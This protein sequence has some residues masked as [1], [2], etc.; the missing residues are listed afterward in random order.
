MGREVVHRPQGRATSIAILAALVFISACT[1]ASPSRPSSGAAPS[2]ASTEPARSVT[3]V[4]AARG[5][6]PSLSARPMRDFGLGGR[7]TVSLFS[8]G[9]AIKDASGT[10]QPYLAE[11]LPQLNT[12]SWR[13]LPDGGMETTYRLRPDL[14]WH[15]GTALTS[16]DWAFSWRVYQV[17]ELGHAGA[18]PIDRIMGI[19]TPDARTLV[20]RWKQPWAQ[21]GML[22]VTDQTNFPPL[23]RHLLEEQFG[24]ANWDGF[25][26]L[27]YWTVEYIGQGPY[28]L[29]RW[30]IGSFLEGSAFDKHSLGRPLIDKVRVMFIADA[31]AVVANLLAGET[32]ITVDS[33]LAFQQGM[34]VRREWAP[35]NVG[36]VL[37]YPVF[38][39]WLVVQQRAEF[40]NPRSLRDI[41]VRKALAHSI[42][43]SALNEA[44]FEGEGIMADSP[45]SNNSAF[46][47]LVDRATAKYPYDLRM[48]EQLMTE[49]GYTKGGDGTYQSAA[50]GRFSTELSVL[51][52][53]QNQQELGIVGAG[54]RQLG[55]DVGEIVWPQAYGQ[56]SQLRNTHPGLSGTN[57]PGGPDA[58]L[59]YGVA[60]LPRPENRWLGSNRG[61]WTNPEFDRLAGTFNSTLVHEERN[62][63]L[64]QLVRVLTSDAAYISL[65]FN[66]TVTAYVT[67]LTGPGVVPPDGDV[68]WNVHLWQYQSPRS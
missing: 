55:F 5:E 61:G 44:L 12:D 67:G 2:G 40:A 8:R 32:Q 4:M 10:S 38:Y 30:E 20:I 16:E 47:S 13:V 68:A 9:L 50:D 59:D 33:P 23:P 19:D 35:R 46:F 31:N 21:A 54:W 48:T 28:R 57:G 14:T 27:P 3:L 39:R 49:A 7:S 15:D 41:R 53:V 17:P 22:D 18:S 64:A 26:A 43:K 1:S 51:A 34:I 58:V 24:R 36:T 37:V 56:D 6:M 25:V 63:I 60:T 42:D 52:N 11:T 29:D 62:Q 66:P 45:I 65:W